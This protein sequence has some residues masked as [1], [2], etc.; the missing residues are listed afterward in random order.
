MTC[1]NV[2]VQGFSDSQPDLWD[3]SSML[4]GLLP[5]GSVFAFLAEHRLALFPESMFAD[6]FPSG[7]GR[8]STPPEVVASVMVLQALHGLSD[9]AAAE[10][11]TFDLRWKAACGL[12]VDAPAFHPTVL[13]YWRKRLAGSESPN[14]I[15]DAVKAVIAQTG[16]LAG[17][18]R[19]ALDSTVL[20][21]AVATQDTITQ[22]KAAVRKV[23]ALVPGG[24]DAV[25]VHGSACDYATAG[26]PD[27]AWDDPV[28]RADLVDALVRDAVAVLAAMTGADADPVEPDTTA[29]QALALLALLAGQDVEWV[30]PDDDTAGGGRWRIAHRVASERVISTVDPDARHARKTRAN[31]Q[32]GYKGHISIEPDTGL[33]TGAAVTKAAGAGSGDA[34]AGAVLLRGET[35]STDDDSGVRFEVLGDSAYGSGEFLA[36]LTES[37]HVANI[38]PHPTPAHIENGF[39]ADDFTVDHDNKTVVCPAG[40]TV[41]FANKSATARFKTCCTGCP[42]RLR[43]T[44]ARAGREMK[45]GVHDRIH[46]AHR[47]R[48]NTDD[49]LRARY[50]R[51]RPMVERSIAW[52][53]RGVRTLRYR[54]VVKNDAWWQL[55]AASINLRRIAALGATHN[56]GS[57]QMA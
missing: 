57:W 28:A 52:M 20:N 30:E 6:L 18:T 48:W 7:R 23:A 55:R 8:P 26:K 46:R 42:F 32:D 27:I 25:A 14:R 43:C 9:R 33:V 44:T 15:F 5:Q 16:V 17:R 56:Q 10:A 53:T 3:T 38:K 31:R 50:R 22:L 39:T 34:A 21:D 41:S 45:I 37:G 49:A 29:G 35:D 36:E 13:T 19:R 1:D 54:G 2:V 24:A 47:A 11:V 4:G 40:H 51:H 12:A